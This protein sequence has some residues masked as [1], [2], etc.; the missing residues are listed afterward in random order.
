MELT[1]PEGQMIGVA[2]QRLPVEV[3]FVSKKRSVSPPPSI[4]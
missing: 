4:F 1:Y 3:S 2:K